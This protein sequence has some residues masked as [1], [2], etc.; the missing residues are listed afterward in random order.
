MIPTLLC[1]AAATC[2]SPSLLPAACFV[3]GSESELRTSNSIHTH[4]SLIPSASFVPDLPQMSDAGARVAQRIADNA[5]ALATRL[6]FAQLLAVCTFMRDV[7]RL[8]LPAAL[9]DGLAAQ[10]RAQLSRLAPEQLILGLSHLLRTSTAKA[11]KGD[12]VPPAS[13]HTSSPHQKVAGH[14]LPS[15]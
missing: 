3:W 15:A 4:S 12:P 6:S 8:S 14:L 9:R 5:D 7:A 1:F 2:L 13:S 11:L 10:L